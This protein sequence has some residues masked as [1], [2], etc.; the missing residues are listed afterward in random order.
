MAS[1]SLVSIVAAGLILS[2][3]GDSAVAA[4]IFCPRT[5]TETPTVA[6]AN[7][8]WTVVALLG[9]RPLE[10]VGVYL[11]DPPEHGAQVPDST[12]TIKKARIVKWRLVRAEKDTFWVGC[13]YVGTTAMLFQKLDAKVSACAATYDLLPSGRPQR[14]SGMV[15]H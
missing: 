6:T 14:L 10:G 2:F 1:G 8:Q 11:G 15:C 13:T 9:E 3:S 4:E 7:N 12:K 5:I